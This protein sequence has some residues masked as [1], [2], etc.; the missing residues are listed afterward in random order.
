MVLCLQAQRRVS[1]DP[2]GRIIMTN[3]YFEPRRG[4][5]LWAMKTK[6]GEMANSMLTVWGVR[7]VRWSEPN[8]AKYFNNSS[9][10]SKNKNTR[11]RV[12][13]NLFLITF[14]FA[15]GL[16]SHSLPSGM[17]TRSS[18]TRWCSADNRQDCGGVSSKTVQLF[19]RGDHKAAEQSRA[20]HRPTKQFQ[21]PGTEQMTHELKGRKTRRR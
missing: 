4:Y 9:H 18:S 14:F 13:K 19:P 8:S 11:R 17:D 1:C 6:G 3:L 16:L 15:Y 20:G 12:C 10:R 5:H 2:S 21:P 7:I